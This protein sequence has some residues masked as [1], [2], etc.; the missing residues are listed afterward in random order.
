[1]TE[2][3]F[4]LYPYGIHKTLVI[5]GSAR[6]LPKAD[7]EAALAAVERKI[8]ER[9]FGEDEK[10]AMLRRARQD[11]KNSHYYEAARQLSYELTKWTL[12]AYPL[13]ADRFYVCSGG[14][15][16]IME[17]ANRGA[18]EA[19][20]KTM[21]LGI[22]LPKEQQL[23][24]YISPTLGFNFRYFFVRKYWFLKLARALI[25]FPGGF[26]TMDELFEMLTLVQTGK[27]GRKIPII[28]FGR[29]FWDSV[30]NFKKF[31]ELGYISPEDLNDF[32]I[33][34]TV[35]EA[36]EIIIREIT[37]GGPLADGP[38]PVDMD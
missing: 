29:E 21:G 1:M 34:D 7:A 13:A 19:G 37:A 10:K 36:R 6:T 14:G 20:G 3:A 31:D 22:T 33:V 18:F 28:L 5:F 12:E 16:G 30:V 4:R 23:N 27:S 15:P 24:P 9:P 25:V 26:G 2:P 32:V 8:A 17:A 35:A 11:L 38:D